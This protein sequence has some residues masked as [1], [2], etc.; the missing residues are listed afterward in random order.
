MCVEIFQSKGH[1]V[2]LIKT[3]PEAE[4]MKVIGNYD[5]LVV[6]SATKVCIFNPFS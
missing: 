4:L 5:A 1:T 6:R 3:L 2:D